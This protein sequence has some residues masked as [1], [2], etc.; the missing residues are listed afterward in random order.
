MIP[1]GPLRLLPQVRAAEKDTKRE[2]KTIHDVI[3]G[4][5]FLCL[6]NPSSVTF[7]TGYSEVM[8]F[9]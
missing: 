2:G 4:T 8:R 9:N 3:K 7:P 6:Q 5:V 1:L